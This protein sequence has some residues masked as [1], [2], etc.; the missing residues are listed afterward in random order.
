MDNDKWND[1]L[2]EYVHV[3]NATKLDKRVKHII[4]N[5][6]YGL[7]ADIINKTEE[8]FYNKLSYIGSWDGLR[9]VMIETYIDE[10]IYP[11]RLHTKYED[12]KYLGILSKLFDNTIPSLSPPLPQ[13]TKSDKKTNVKLNICDVNKP[14]KNRTKY[15]PE[16]V[17]KAFD[18]F[19]HKHNIPIKKGI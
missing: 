3:L 10:L 5:S 14:N 6:Y 13:H 19:A 15:S 18:D 8:E 9:M 2:R 7:M 11:T 1:R 4:Q 17:S 12:V 16:T